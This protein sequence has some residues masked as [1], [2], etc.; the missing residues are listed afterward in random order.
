M[1]SSLSF[2][3]LSDITMDAY[4]HNIILPKKI[5]AALSSESAEG[6]VQNRCDCYVFTNLSKNDAFLT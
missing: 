4:I 5:V 3:A 2:S 1:A 6:I